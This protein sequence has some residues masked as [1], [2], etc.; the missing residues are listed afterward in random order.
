MKKNTVQAFFL[1][2]A[3]LAGVSGW[4]QAKKWSIE[5]C[6]DY[7]V[8]H[9]ISIQQSEL[10]QKSSGVDKEGAIGAF[11]PSLNFN[12]SH[13]W[14]TGLNQ[15]ISTGLFVNQTVQ[16]TSL[17]INSSI[18]IYQG[19]QLQNRFR[20]ANLAILASQ[21]KLN[22][23]K[24]DVSLN[25]ANAYLQIL[26][27]KEQLNVQ[28]EQMQN[29]EKQLQRT[30]ELVNAGAKPKGDLLDMK[31]TL[32]GSKQSVVMAQNSL[33]ISKLSLAQLLQLPDFQEFDTEDKIYELRESDVMQQTPVD[34]FNKAK[35]VRSEI[36]IAKTNLEL[37]EKDVKIA[38]GVYQP[39]LSGAFN[40]QSSASYSDR[41]TGY[42]SD[43]QPIFAPPLPIDEQFK[44]N[45]SHAFIL[46]LRVP[47]LNGL[48]ARVNVERN[49]INLE[50]SKIAYTQQELDL[51]RNV[52]TA[53]TDAKGAL[54][55]YESAMT[56]LEARAEAFNYAKE[57]Y[58]VGMLSA[59]DLN[60]SQ[61]LYVNAKSDLL[62]TK[63]DYIFK[64]KVLEFYFGIPIVR[65]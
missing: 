57:K 46:Q 35:E 56:T 11:L 50:R 1:F 58:N 45:R 32:A 9:N 63:Y 19:L 42:G 21:Y 51:E 12:S 33:L 65:N 28:K 16:F 3:T 55:A 29:N 23:M 53:F 8:K 24:D 10:D 36:K 13:T 2:C 48:S 6:L 22:K 17:G 4:S 15:N 60:Q 39:T 30:Q 38:K 61:T 7:A 47:I 52:Y 26:F 43:G 44:N 18:P 25:V 27:N 64:V 41:V 20:R 37:A 34:I 62:R 59:F 31:A 5:E 40:M 49:K 14:N 54:Q